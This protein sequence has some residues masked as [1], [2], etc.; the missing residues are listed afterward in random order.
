MCSVI[1][2]LTTSPIDWTLI[3]RVFNLL[4]FVALLFFILRRP[5]GDAFRAR[6]E[7][8]RRDLMRAQE[9]RD[10]ALAKLS[11]VE[12]RLANLDREV[13]ALHAQA[14]AEA[15][16]ERVRIERS[17]DED[18][19][20]LREQAQ[21]EITSAGKSARAELRAYAAEQSVRLAEDIIRRELRPEDDSRLVNEYVKELGGVGR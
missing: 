15:E 2:L 18:L 20:K 16:Q 14:L 13:E 6:Q 11:E 1:V 7:R 5:I 4:L 21:R 19:R 12:A 8:I 10:A 3:A 9:E 17:T